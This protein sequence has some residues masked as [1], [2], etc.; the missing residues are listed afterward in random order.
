VRIAA[1]STVLLALAGTAC[2]HL[3]YDGSL[4]ATGTP[5]PPPG[6]HFVS[7]S[8]SGGSGR[9]HSVPAGI[10]CTSACTAA[11]AGGTSVSLAFEP[12]G[13]DELVGW[14]LD[15]DGQVAN[16]C[17][18]TADADRSVRARLSKPDVPV[19]AAALGGSGADRAS[20]IALT[21][22]EPVAGGVFRGSAD[23]GAGCAVTSAGGDDLFVARFDRL[24]G[25]CRWA[26]RFGESSDEEL[27]SIAA[28]PD[29][30]A[31]A[32]SFQSSSVAFGPDLLDL[33]AADPQD[34]FVAGLDP[35]TGA[36]AWGRALAHS[37]TDRATAVA[38]SPSGVGVAGVFTGSGD[39]AFV[40]Q[41]P[42]G[43]GSPSFT[44][45]IGS[46]GP[47]EIAAIAA[48]SAGWI[49]A[50]SYDSFGFTIPQQGAIP[51]DVAFDD[52]WAAGLDTNGSALWA[53][54]AGGQQKE[55]ANA[56]VPLEDGSFLLVGTLQTTIQTGGVSLTALGPDSRNDTFVIHV[57][58]AGVGLGG[59]VIGG[60]GDQTAL[61]AA[62]TP[63]GRIALAGSYS[64]AFSAG[65]V[66]FPAP[67]GSSDAFVLVLDAS[68]APVSGFAIGSAGADAANA[69]A[70]D[71]LGVAFV[72][73]TIGGSV[74]VGGQTLGHGG[75]DALVFALPL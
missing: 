59:T 13:S 18:V 12:T 74:S 45:T 71:D 33:G 68:L 66:S 64:A 50:G 36:G 32:G 9:I 40:M 65:P 73:A 67:S 56:I 42:L 28:G 34:S 49:V 25:A 63:D 17:A 16:P 48:T 43:G 55:Y 31:L 72:T 15:C 75:T 46:G 8:F 14:E 1:F 21:S 44:R 29:L 26:S 60:S 22:G 58:S 5:T 41:L 11:F 47:Q 53:L 7:V 51:D 69:I 52:G 4:P 62:A 19:W 38:V 37:S 35:Q 10:D 54:G 30:V 70:V 23:L 24:S 20:G 27:L 57:S 39:D 61:A 6:T 3:T 2:A